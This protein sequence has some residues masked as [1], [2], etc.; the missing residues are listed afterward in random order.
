MPASPLLLATPESL[1]T[2]RGAFATKSLWVTPHSDSERW[3]AGDYTIQSDGG[4]GLAKWT[5]GDRDLVD[6]VLWVTLGAAHVPRVEDF[7]VM[8][9]EVVGFHLKPFCF[10]DGNPGV[11]VPHGVNAASKLDGQKPCCGA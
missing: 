4:E 2:S 9:T 3:P 8:P 7:P 10:F 1:L 11:D 5:A 6:P